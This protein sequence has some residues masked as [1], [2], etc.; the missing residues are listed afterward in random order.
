V[1]PALRELALQRAPDG[2]S[3]TPCSNPLDRFAIGDQDKRTLDAEDSLDMY[4]Q[5]Q[6]PGEGEES[7]CSRPTFSVTG[8]TTVGIP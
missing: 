7:N 6:T 1:T 3:L 5:A 4:V 2:R 8:H